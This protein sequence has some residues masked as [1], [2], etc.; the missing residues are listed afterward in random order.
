MSEQTRQA[1]KAKLDEIYTKVDALRERITE[2]EN[3]I[4]ALYASASPELPEDREW[5]IT[6]MSPSE[7]MLHDLTEMM[8]HRSTQK[9]AEDLVRPNDF[10]NQL[11]TS[12]VGTKLKIHF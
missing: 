6:Q 2:I 12:Q 11:A 7:R 10:V 9:L 8:L 3:E 1:R 5:R 4:D